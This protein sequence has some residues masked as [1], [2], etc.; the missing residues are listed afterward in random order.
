M[1]FKD[2]LK[3][4]REDLS[5]SQKEVAKACDLSPQCI[6]QLEMG[7]RNPTG[8][9]LLALSNF[10]DCSIDFLMGKIEDYYSSQT[11]ENFPHLTNKRTELLAIYDSLTSE[12]QAQLL[13]YA[14]FC[15]ERS[16]EQ[17]NN[18]VAK[19]NGKK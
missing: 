14:R 6:S 16:S 1:L 4:L 11:Y 5:L 2:I 9:T 8:T 19:R 17:T 18:T 12:F 10:F 15:K 13:E 7:T 3:E